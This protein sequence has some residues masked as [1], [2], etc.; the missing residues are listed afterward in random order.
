MSN[1]QPSTLFFLQHTATRII[2]KSNENKHLNAI[3]ILYHNTMLGEYMNIKIY[4][5]HIYISINVRYY[6]HQEGIIII[7]LF[8]V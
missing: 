5:Y 4:V 6:K 8:F 1:A 7:L 2:G 3:L